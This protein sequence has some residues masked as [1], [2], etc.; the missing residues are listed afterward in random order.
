MFLEEIKDQLVNA[1]VGIYAENIF[2]SSASVIPSGDGPYLTL[3]ET[4]GSGPARMH[5]SAT[6]RPTAQLT[7]RASTEVEA[8]AF[9]KKAYD[10]L[11][12]ADGLHNITLLGVNYVSITPRQEPTDVSLD[13]EARATFV[14]NIDAEKQPS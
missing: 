11:G 14:F 9:L 8:R 10:A 4:G 13:G 5:N 12:G 1:G 7:S 3:V 6:Q 2:I